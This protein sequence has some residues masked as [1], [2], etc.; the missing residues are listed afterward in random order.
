MYSPTC[1][2]RIRRSYIF[3]F[4][5]LKAIAARIRKGVVGRRGRK[6]PITPSATSTDPASVNKAFLIFILPVRTGTGI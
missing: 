4:P 5:A 6:I 2:V 1:L 3:S